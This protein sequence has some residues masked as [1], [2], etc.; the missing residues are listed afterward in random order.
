MHLIRKA[1]W[2]R[3]DKQAAVSAVWQAERKLNMPAGPPG[4]KSLVRSRARECE[5]KRRGEVKGVLSYLAVCMSYC[6]YYIMLGNV[7]L[8][9]PFIMKYE[10]GTYKQM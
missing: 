3:V 1:Y 2:K 7:I 6:Y 4:D 5:A 9:L 8:S 10:K